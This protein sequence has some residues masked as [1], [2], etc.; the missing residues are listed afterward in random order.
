MEHLPYIRKSFSVAFDRA[1]DSGIEI[2]EI[3]IGAAEIEIHM[4]M[5]ARRRIRQ[6]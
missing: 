1:P 4:E 5:S 3:G 2:A 6:R